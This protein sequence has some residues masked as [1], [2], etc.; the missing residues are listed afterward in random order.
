MEN[1]HKTRLVYIENY[2]MLWVQSNILLLLCIGRYAIINIDK[3]RYLSTKFLTSQEHFKEATEPEWSQ[4][5]HLSTDTVSSLV[6]QTRIT[7]ETMMMMMMMMMMR[8]R[9]MVVMMM[10]IR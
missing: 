3:T 2:Y 5:A 6:M 8:R 9:M 7:T 4:V 10:M 1:F